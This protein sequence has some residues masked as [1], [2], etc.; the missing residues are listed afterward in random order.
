MHAMQVA[1]V[2]TTLDENLHKKT[3]KN[4]IYRS[5]DVD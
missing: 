1:T 2:N 3:N 5:I 4:K